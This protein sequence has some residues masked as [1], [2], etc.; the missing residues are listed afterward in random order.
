MILDSGSTIRCEVSL[1]I[2]SLLFLYKWYFQR[3]IG[4]SIGER[5]RNR[6]LSSMRRWRGI[7]RQLSRWCRLSGTQSENAAFLHYSLL[8]IAP[9]FLLYQFHHLVHVDSILSGRYVHLMKEGDTSSLSEGL[10]F[11]N[12]FFVFVLLSQSF[13]IGHNRYLLAK[14]LTSN[15]HYLPVL[16]FSTTTHAWTQISILHILI[17]LKYFPLNLIKHVFWLSFLI[18]I[19]LKLV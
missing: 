3:R 7:L 15:F 18:I 2:F 17:E 12:Y 16:W 11:F 6:S 14:L 9:V 8:C 13:R 4:G 5:R 1:C 10:H 19:N